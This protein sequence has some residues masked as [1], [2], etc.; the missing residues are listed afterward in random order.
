MTQAAIQIEPAEKA[1]IEK[2][3]FSVSVAG[4]AYVVRDKKNKKL[5][6]K[7]KLEGGNLYALLCRAVD[8]RKEVDAK[9][10]AKSPGKAAS[11]PKPVPATAASWM[12]AAARSAR[13]RRR[14]RP[15]VIRP[16][17][18]PAA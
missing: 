14:S 9:Q 7:G 3:D 16:L 1:I 2:Y 6:N 13:R 4:N 8:E 5:G 18:R 12:T 11:A 15:R 10:A 17:S